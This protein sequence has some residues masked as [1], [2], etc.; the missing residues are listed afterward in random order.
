MCCR[1]NVY[2]LDKE[3]A[4]A[5]LAIGL[6]VPD[7]DNQVYKRALTDEE[8]AVMASFRSSYLNLSI[9]P[10]ITV[11]DHHD[12]KRLAAGVMFEIAARYAQKVNGQVYQRAQISECRE[13]E[14]VDPGGRG[15]L[16]A[17]YPEMPL[18]YE[19]LCHG[20]QRVLGGING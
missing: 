13:P 3:V 20:W 14:R 19:A 4:Q 2:P 1:V 5:L 17:S 8:T 16:V 7:S 9:E 10:A 11:G 6:F 12:P 15:V 18:R